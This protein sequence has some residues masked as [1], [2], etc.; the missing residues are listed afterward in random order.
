M[1]GYRVSIAKKLAPVPADKNVIE[2]HSERVT[3]QKLGAGTPTRWPWPRTVMVIFLLSLLL[4]G[5]VLA[6]ASLAFD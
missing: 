4:W 3:S 1:R 6:I 5:G 2:L